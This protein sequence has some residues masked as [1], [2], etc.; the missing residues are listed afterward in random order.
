MSALWAELHLQ[1]DPSTARAAATQQAGS[2][3]SRIRS[4][5]THFRVKGA[6]ESESG[7]E[8]TSHAYNVD[9]INHD[10]NI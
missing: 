3:G 5:W 10:S 6:S 8:R 9:W 7:R 1:E 4:L 2:Q